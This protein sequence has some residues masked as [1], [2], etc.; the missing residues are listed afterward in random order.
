M[1][2]VSYF[3]FALIMLF[4]CSMSTFAKEIIVVTGDD[5]R[6]RSKPTTSGSTIITSFNSGT[7]LTLLDKNGG[8]I[9]IKSKVHKGTE[10]VITIPTKG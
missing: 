5:V 4:I 7:E 9:D 3:V 10:V 2:K 8:R 1:K 6:F